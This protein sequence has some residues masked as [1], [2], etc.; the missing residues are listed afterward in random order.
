MTDLIV[1]T[2]IK[3]H[4][5]INDQKVRTKY[6]ILSGCVGIAVNVILCLLKFFV[7]SLTG[8]IAITADAVNNLSD[9]GS[10]AVTVFGF[11]MAGK[12]ADRDHPF[13]HG[14][15]E[16]ITAMIVSFIILFMGIELA[17]QSVEKIRSPENVQFSLV[18]AIIIAVSILGKLWLAF[19]NKGLGK[20]INSPAMTAVVAD[21]ISDIAATSITLI[22]LI[23]SNFFPNLHIDGWLGIVVAC[24]VLKAGLEIFRD[25]LSTLIGKSPS[26]ELVEALKKKILSYDHVSG[27][28]DLIVHSYGPGRDF[29]TV[30]VEMPSDLNVMVG[31][32]IIDDIENDVKKEMGIDLTI[33]YDP[34]E[35]N[36][37]R[38]TELK[39]I[40]ENVV[41]KVNPE[42]SIHDF[43]IV[44]GPM[45]TN[46]IFDVVIPYGFK[47]SPKE[48][49]SEISS[50]ISEINS[51]YFTVI[52]AEHSFV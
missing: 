26:K 43:R 14:R 4:K 11:K 37:E 41:R 35:V 39:E 25:T 24:F 38:V 29:A 45:H 49:I 7:G 5:N 17:I 28:H 8:S 40:T 33:H 16:Y 47:E 44:D 50:Q 21:S 1:K 10:S 22:A 18:G 12:P 31:H 51:S 32:N 3:D 30:H 34:I 2:F 13:G 23:L 27:I 52:K 46:L 42:L 20:K 6:G 19:F 48:I 9:A 36:N 15:I